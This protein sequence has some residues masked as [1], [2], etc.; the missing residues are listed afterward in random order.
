[1][2]LPFVVIGLGSKIH[3]FIWK[4]NGANGEIAITLIAVE[5]QSDLGMSSI[6]VKKITA[7]I[8]VCKYGGSLGDSCRGN[9]DSDSDSDDDDDY[10]AST[11]PLDDQAIVVGDENPAWY[12]LPVLKN[13]VIGAA[14]AAA[15]GAI[16]G[17]LVSDLLYFSFINETKIF[18]VN[19]ANV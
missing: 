13:A 16:A 9:D 12:K 14:G 2:H 6:Q 8:E 1:L 7:S 11:C 19:I 5:L 4:K 17:K 10:T 18:D 15:V 3:D